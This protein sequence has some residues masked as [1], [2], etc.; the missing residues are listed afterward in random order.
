MEFPE[1]TQPLDNEDIL[2]APE[3]QPASR[4]ADKPRQSDK[5]ANKPTPATKP[6][7][8]PTPKPAEPLPEYPEGSEGDDPLFD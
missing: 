4:P 3:Q 6:A 5:P 1:Q 2:P 7:P 8:Q